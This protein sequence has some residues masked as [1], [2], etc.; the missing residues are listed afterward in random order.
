MN[1]NAFSSHVQ[2]FSVYFEYKSEIDGG[3]SVSDEIASFI[4]KSII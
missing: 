3:I 2:S 4:I 1:F